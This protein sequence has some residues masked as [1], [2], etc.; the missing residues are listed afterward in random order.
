MFSSMKIPAIDDVVIFVLDEN[1]LG[2][3]RDI[4]SASILALRSQSIT[5]AS[6]MIL[7]GSKDYQD[8]NELAVNVFIPNPTT[9]CREKPMSI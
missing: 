2:P 8:G 6:I 9:G 7:Q 4:V 5:H 1:D 3:N